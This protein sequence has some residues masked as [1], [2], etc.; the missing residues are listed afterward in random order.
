MGFSPAGYFFKKTVQ[1]ALGEK[2][3]PETQR[4]LSDSRRNFLK[5]SGSLA[6]G[7][8]FAKE[9]FEG[10][11]AGSKPKI[12]IIGAGAAGLTAGYSLQKANLPYTIYEASGRPG[13]RMYSLRDWI[14][15]DIATDLGGEFVDGEHTA[16]RSLCEELKIELYD[17]RKDEF[18]EKKFFIV[19]GKKYFP[20]DIRDGLLPFSKSILDDI[21]SLP[22]NL[23]YTNGAAFAGFDKITILEYLD[24]K[25]INGWLRK[26]I[27]VIY[28]AEYGMESAEQTAMNF[29]VT[30]KPPDSSANG[31]YR[32][33]GDDHEI[34]KIK[35]GSQTI[36]D[37]LFA[38]QQSSVKLHH[39]ITG[40]ESISGN[41]YRLRITE[42][43]NTHFAAADYLLICIPF[44]VLRG[45]ETNIQ[46]PEL[47]KLAID[48]LGY[49][50]SSK[51]IFGFNKKP[52]RRFEESGVIFSDVVGH[53][54]WDNA[55]AQGNMYSGLTFFSG[56]N[57]SRENAAMKEEAWE[58]QMLAYA[59]K[60]FHTEKNSFTGRKRKVCWAEN[61]FSLGGYTSYKI[62]QWS[63]FGGVEAEPHEN[64]F[65]AGEHCSLEFQG[66]MNGAIMTGYSAAK[67]MMEK[68]KQETQTV[69]AGAR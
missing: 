19:D 54:I 2:I 62:N 32:I 4:Q 36:A 56:G 11:N 49:G 12:A 33:Y 9:F 57:L 51:F 63:R 45:I 25:G 39:R 24:K 43:G 50:N 30:I 65:F 40:Y 48:T 17:L 13:G 16:L 60:E 53:N 69:P 61:P 1:E 26:L 18:F 29:L 67:A 35:G 34:Y 58:Q 23:H 37:K 22:Q 55:F 59:E 10:E 27:D 41:G 52:W 31:V 38:K 20:Q 46:Y 21:T 64:I 68:I 47:K 14:G 8:F 28:T 6:F 3:A 7:S 42:N 15:K 44:S 66:F 5:Q